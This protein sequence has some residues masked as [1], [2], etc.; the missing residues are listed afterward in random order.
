MSRDMEF[1]HT[2]KRPRSGEATGE[3]NDPAEERGDCN[4]FFGEYVTKGKEITIV[5][6]PTLKGWG[7]F[8]APTFGIYGILCLGS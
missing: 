4:I 7:K 8:F 1:A 5:S 2:A 3:L 6:Y